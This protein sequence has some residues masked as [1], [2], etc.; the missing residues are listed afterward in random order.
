MTPLT[1]E[2]LLSRGKCCSMGCRAC[3]YF[4]R[5]SGSK[6]VFKIPDK[7]NCAPSCSIK[8][9]QEGECPCYLEFR[10]NNKK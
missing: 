1:R 8:T 6:E 2:F 7:V 3:P 5:A 9:M 10:E 4:P